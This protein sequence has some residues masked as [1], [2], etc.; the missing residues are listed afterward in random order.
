MTPLHAPRETPC[1]A[2]ACIFS[3]GPLRCFAAWLLSQG[4][5]KESSAMF[6]LYGIAQLFWCCYLNVIQA[7]P[8][9]PLRVSRDVRLDLDRHTVRELEAC[10]CTTALPSA[11]ACGK[12]AVAADKC[13]VQVMGHA[14]HFEGS[15]AWV[16]TVRES[17]KPPVAGTGGDNAGADSDADNKCDYDGTQAANEADGEQ[18]SPHAV[19]SIASRGYK[20]GKVDSS[21][22]EDVSMLNQLEDAAAARGSSG[23][24]GGGTPAHAESEDLDD[25]TQPLPPAAAAPARADAP[26]IGGAAGCELRRTGSDELSDAGQ[27]GGG[28]MST[29]LANLTQGW[30]G[31]L[32]AIAGGSRRRSSDTGCFK[33]VWHVLHTCVWFI[34]LA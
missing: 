26:Q 11:A 29:Y 33:G 19:V 10:A 4:E 6:L 31:R 1:V 32:S 22:S 13:T 3:V 8:C 2:V 16:P 21:S 34:S 30:S 17:V 25:S 15:N 24:T 23:G 28:D 20:A 5:V 12:C 9:Q 18:G 27:G 7:C 14:Q